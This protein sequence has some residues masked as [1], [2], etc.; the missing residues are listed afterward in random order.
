MNGSVAARAA[1]PA[2][3]GEGTVE[4]RPPPAAPGRPAGALFEARVAAQFLRELPRF[5]HHPLTLE[6][7]EAI[8]R[9]RLAGRGTDFLHVM[10]RAV[11]EHPS[12]PYRALLAWA[13]CEFGDLARL[14]ARDGVEGTLLALLRSGVYLTVDELKGRQ[15]VVRGAST[16]A[17]EPDQ[18]RNPHASLHVAARSSASR[19]AGT[20]VVNGLDALRDRA[21]NTCLTLAA[22]GGADWEKGA[23]SVPGSLPLILRYSAFGKPPTGW[24]S[25]VDPRTAGLHPRYRW[26]ERALRWGSAI[27]GV[28]IPPLRHAPPHDPDAVLRWIRDVLDRGGIPH[29]WAFPSAAVRAV[30]VATERGVDIRGTQMTVTGEPVTAARLASIRAAGVE[31]VP[32]YGSAESGGV[33]AYGCLAPE[34]SDDVHLYHDLHAMVQ[35][36]AAGPH[37][38]PAHTVCVSSLRLTSPLILLNASMGDQAVLE[39]RACGC[40]LERLG[41]TTHLHTIRSFEKL[42]AGGVTFLDADVV[43]VLEDT[44]PARFGGGPLDFQLVEDEARDGRPRLRLLV[45]PRLGALPEGV[46]ADAFL[47]AIAS[48]SGAA[49]V[50]GTLWREMD[51]LTVERRAPVTTAG[52]KVQH[53]HA[54]TADRPTTRG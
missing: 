29:L 12:S 15:P 40:P 54:A 42:T 4:G 25:C 50:A 2:A 10:R 52:G 21:V 37:A 38:L 23:W 36:A 53:V 11:Y 13:G 49:R 17:I 32:D 51:V 44:L 26:S 1:R 18:L 33:V 16:L 31:A 43:R 5:L 48:G 30:L 3:G 14:V 7:A 24:F 41:W 34:T 28:R 20:L 8:L 45:H 9:E 46:I 6:Q 35:P 39:S 47:D 27:V 22:R 19:G